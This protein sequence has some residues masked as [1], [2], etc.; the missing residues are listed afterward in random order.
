MTRLIWDQTGARY[1]EAGV[2]RG[3]LYVGSAPGVSWDGL[4]NVEE[5][6]SGGEARPRYIDGVKY[7]NTSADEEFEATLSA[8]TYPRIFEQCDGIAQVRPGLGLTNQRRVPFHLTY[9]TGVGND[10]DG[11]G[12]GYKIHLV[13]NALA[14]V[15]SRSHATLSDSSEPLEFSWDLT[16]LPPSIS[17]YKRTAHVTI[18]SRYTHPI[19]LSVI[20]DILYGS[21][22]STPRMLTISELFT[23]YDTLVDLVVVDNGNGTATVSGPDEAIS[24]FAD[25]QYVITWDSVEQIDDDTYS[26]TSP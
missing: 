2:D 17:G 5:K 22:E 12:H 11:A 19:T 15:S 13:Y 24:V 23:I 20:E 21:E 9:R 10:T 4:T 18:D 8:F 25:G 3:V 7:R 6:P 26:I 14:A 16:S 1:Y